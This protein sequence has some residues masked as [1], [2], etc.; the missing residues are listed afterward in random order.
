M[1]LEA[2]EVRAATT[3]AVLATFA[4]AW[5]PIIVKGADVEALPFAFWRLW[6][7]VLVYGAFLRLR[8]GRLSWWVLRESAPGGL[9]FGLNLALFFS[10]VKTTSVANA[11]LI[12][13][14][15]PLLIMVVGHLWLGERARWSDLALTVTAI[16]GVGL[17]MFGGQDASTG[18]LGGDLLAVGAMVT[19][20]LYF[21][22]TKRG[23]RHLDTS[24]YMAGLAVVA[25]LTITPIALVSGQPLLADG[26]GRTW[27]AVVAILAVP[28]SAHVLN[29][30]ALKHVP[31][32]VPSL[33]SL[34]TT[35]LAS[36]LAWM[37][38]DEELVRLQVMGIA[39][40]LGALSMFIL[41]RYRRGASL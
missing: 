29:N 13:T 40:V 3:A 9:A 16:G 39:V 8:G 21:I 19:F 37:L 31:L 33:L 24:E 41:G 22:G 11:T 20:A 6:L 36:A 4:F 23:R 14:L 10:A 12:T 28:G 26:D 2:G 15:Q 5:G 27:L 25:A 7:S 17:V 1:A 18:D 32:L 35:V 34:S 30:Y 38:L